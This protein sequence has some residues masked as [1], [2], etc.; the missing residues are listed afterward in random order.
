MLDGVK[1]SVGV[2]VT[3]LLSEVFGIPFEEEEEG[4]T[5]GVTLDFTGTRLDPFNVN[6]G[7]LLN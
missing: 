4:L 2:D 5:F 1:L 6:A 3:E 7:A